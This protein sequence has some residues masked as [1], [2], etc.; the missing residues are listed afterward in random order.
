MW[1]LTD[2]ILIA[3]GSQNTTITKIYIHC[4]RLLRTFRCICRGVYFAKHVVDL[5][6]VA[7]EVHAA[8]I[9]AA[10]LQLVDDVLAL[11]QI[12]LRRA[13]LLYRIVAYPSH[14]Q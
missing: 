11:H 1:F 3:T 14:K 13:K 6:Q 12:L 10:V 4:G 9:F 5:P 2:H 7:G 8:V